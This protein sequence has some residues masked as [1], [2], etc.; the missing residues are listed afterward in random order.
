MVGSGIGLQVGNLILVGLGLAAIAEY[1][2][3]LPVHIA[4]RSCNG[5]D[6]REWRKAYGD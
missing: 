4:G 5:R 1:F 3:G 2:P 6:C